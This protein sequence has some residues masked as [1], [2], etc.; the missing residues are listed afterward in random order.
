MNKRSTRE[1]EGNMRFGRRKA[2]SGRHR[3][4]IQVLLLTAFCLL[5]TVLRAQ[6]KTTVADALLGPDGTPVV[7]SFV[8]TC[9]RTFVSADGYTVLAQSKTSVTLAA[10]GSFSVN[11]IPNAG[12]SP[13]GSTYLVQ[14]TA[15]NRVVTEI[16][17]VPVSASPVNLAAVRTAS[18][19]SLGVML[20]F[21]QLN[22]PAGCAANQLPQ[23]TGTGWTC[24]ASSGEGGGGTVS[25][26]GLSLPLAVFSVSGSPVTGSGT[27][28]AS[29]ASQSANQILAAPN[30]TA[31][32]PSFRALA[33]A[34]LPA[35]I[36]SSTSGNAATATALASTPNQCAGGQYATGVAASGNANCG[37]PS[38]S[39]G[40]LTTN[41]VPVATSAT[42]LANSSFTSLPAL[43]ATTLGA[44][45]AASGSGTLNASTTYYYTVVPLTTSGIGPASAEG[46]VTTGSGGNTYTVTVPYSGVTGAAG[47]C[48]LGRTTGAEQMISCVYSG[49]TH[50]MAD[51]GSITPS[52]VFPTNSSAVASASGSF[53]PVY[54]D[55]VVFASQMPGSDMCAKISNG[56]AYFVAL[57]LTSGTVDA[58]GIHGV[59]NCAGSMWNN[60][61]DNSVF[62]GTL[63]T[64]SVEIVTAVTQVMP[65]GSLW[66]GYSS[67]AVTAPPYASDIGTTIHP[68]VG[69]TP[70]TP[71]IQYGESTGAYPQGIRVKRL[72]I[73]CA[74]PTGAVIVGAVGIYDAYANEGSGAEDLR[75]GG[76]YTG[77]DI[78]GP[79]AQNEG[80]WDGITFQMD[81]ATD[82]N[83]ACVRFSSTIAY[84]G[85]HTMHAFSCNYVNTSH[86]Q[87]NVGIYID[88][89]NVS[90]EDLHAEGEVVPIEIGSINSV[91]GLFIK[92]VNCLSHSYSPMTS[93]IDIS[94]A[95]SVVAAELHSIVLATAGNVTNTLADHGTNGCTLLAST[96]SNIGF[97][98]RDLHNRITSSMS[99]CS[100]AAAQTATA[101]AATPTQCT[102]GQ[103]A[104]GVAASG[105]ANCGT[106]SGG[107]NVSNSGTPAA[108]QLAQWTNSTTIQGIST[109]PAAAMPTPTASTLGG[110]E[111]STCASHTWQSQISTAG[112]PSSSQPGFSDIS[113]T[114][115]AAQLPAPTASALGGV[116]S[117][118][119]AA[120]NWISYIDTSGV[121]HQ[122]Q[123]ASSDLSDYGT[124]PGAA[125]GNQTANQVLAGPSS[126]A[127]AAPTFRALVAADLGG[128]NNP[129]CD[130]TDPTCLTF[131]EEFFS[132]SGSTST[133]GNAVNFGVPWE[134]RFGCGTSGGQ[135]LG[136]TGQST[137]FGLAS[138]TDCT[139]ATA[140]DTVAAHVA[141]GSVSMGLQFGNIANWR[142]IL[143][144]QL[145]AT[146]GQAV[147][148]GFCGT[149]TTASSLCP[150]ASGSS[151]A[152]RYDVGA[153][154]TG[155]YGEMCNGTACA[156][157]SSALCSVDTNAH[158]FLMYS[159]TAHTVYFSCDAGTAYSVSTDYP[160]GGIVPTFWQQVEATA[161]QHTLKMS[162]FRLKIWGLS[163]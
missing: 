143:R 134:F 107:G 111:S 22:P 76:C 23:W 75:I 100:N 158:T 48:L 160:T 33:A 21:A 3:A 64:E 105:N 131:I 69:F 60:Y 24:V 62:S 43:A 28:N 152:I 103:F 1:R 74:P 122:S 139:T 61:S 128:S 146:T 161:A 119:S 130:A 147:R 162:F 98:V 79:S 142:A 84:T 65:S 52:G 137:E 83:S 124:L 51:N 8:V 97:Y 90:L 153:G 126:G 148:A 110:V 95:H 47:Y 7:G 11:L 2:E 156:S 157:T 144:M 118:V 96:A 141:N 159:T 27:L 78:E 6:V 154:D 129:Y 35:S 135:L 68:A 58:R 136:G 31:G 114:V 40:G 115:A 140:A 120:H 116:E 123:P 145:D 50:S 45:T 92:N 113:G 106:P 127:A 72:A 108:N 16:W 101:L 17:V 4:G 37:T 109:V 150:G 53:V 151:I 54:E 121:P 44:I 29:F 56:W 42:T 117:I 55:G 10:N 63:L 102:G 125:F 38:G 138:L 14:Y 91:Y 57:G 32:A 59:Q 81:T 82:P 12:S 132:D 155:F 93:C 15:N 25:S 49:S 20:P 99:D 5:P 112:V 41:L 163:R 39:L 85:R 70:S 104:T 34:D 88:G 94:S 77:L 13:G 71:I 67:R 26:V 73:S 87:A 66:D 80:F 36:T 149:G 9:P 86:V 89:W 46:S 133:T 18:P 30:G 19:P